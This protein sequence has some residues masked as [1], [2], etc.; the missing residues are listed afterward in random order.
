MA[1]RI[2]GMGDVLT[3]IEK[4]EAN[5]DE[6]KAREIAEKLKKNKFTL[7]DYYDQL[8]QLKSMGSLSDIAG[9]IPGVDA[10]ELAGASLDDKLLI[11]LSLIHI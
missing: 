7:S 8:I 1:S 3:L 2:L 10:K 5:Y 11:R 4:A 6:K 9:M